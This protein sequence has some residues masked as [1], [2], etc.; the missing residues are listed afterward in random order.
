[1][2][3]L[4]KDLAISSLELPF[5][6]IN[7]DQLHRLRDNSLQRRNGEMSERTFAGGP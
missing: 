4:L 5:S 7:A 1:M 2:S 6:L 3:L